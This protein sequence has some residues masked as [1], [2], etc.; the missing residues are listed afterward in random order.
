[1]LRYWI[2]LVWLSAMVPAQPALDR[3]SC[4]AAAG[5]HE[6]LHAVLWMRSS[7][8]YRHSAIQAYRLAGGLLPAALA[9]RAWTA[10]LEQA[11]GYEN[12][13]PAVILDIDETV[14]DNSP[15]QAAFMQTGAGAFSETGWDEWVE[16][17]EAKTVP[18]ALEFLRLSE[19]SGVE[20]FYVTNR[21]HKHEGK[22]IENLKAAGA[23][24]A[25]E[26]HVLT[27]GEVPGWG[28]DKTSR[29]RY[30]ASRYRILLLMGDDAGDFLSGVRSA[31]ADREAAI[32]PFGSY[33]GTRWIVLPNPAYGSWESALSGGRPAQSREQGLKDKCAMLR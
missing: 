33:L 16:R 30:L 2:L 1:M 19:A 26:A 24:F 14:L 8:E 9:D 6:N 5:N 12:L 27:K 22:T 31:V 25:D 10:A 21:E 4:G 13:P 20:V 15:S 29:R 3:T 18:G 28:S 11:A 32:A 17:A 23:P 7:L